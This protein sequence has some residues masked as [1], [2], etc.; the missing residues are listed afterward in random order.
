MATI[1]NPPPEGNPDAVTESVSEIPD[2]F[3]GKSVAEV[4]EAYANLEKKM[5]QQSQELG[6][7][8]TL[9]DQQN[10]APAATPEA[11]E[12]DFYADPEKATR[13]MIREELSGLQ[14]TVSGQQRREVERQLDASHPGWQDIVKSDDFINWVSKS[15]ARIRLFQAADQADYDSAV[16][17]FD[18]WGEK[19]GN[20]QAAQETAEKA[21]EKDRKIRAASTDKGS[22]KIDGR[23]VLS[24]ADLQE[25]KRTNPDRYNAL[26][27][28]IRK[29]YAEGRVR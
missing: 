14:S 4:A 10:Q 27:P 6:Q 5:G 29:A 20:K 7:L 3:Q 9:I 2:R 13:K 23:R 16:E 1:T 24:R 28:D 11:E 15:K 8:R 22:T 25:L 18:W 17:L 12:I 21:V 26:L 19:S